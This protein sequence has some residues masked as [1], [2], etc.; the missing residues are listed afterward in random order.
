MAAIAIA[1]PTYDGGKHDLGY[2][3]STSGKVSISVSAGF[4]GGVAGALEACW[5]GATSASINVGYKHELQVW[6]KG[7]GKQYFDFLTRSEISKWC[8]GGDYELTVIT[9]LASKS[10]DSFYLHL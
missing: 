5:A 1:A 4:T 10:Y 9:Q 8:E 6:I 7:A 3:G 2:G